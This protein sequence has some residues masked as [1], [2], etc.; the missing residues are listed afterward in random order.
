MQNTDA[1]RGGIFKVA[2][3]MITSSIIN[4]CSSFPC[5]APPVYIY[6]LTGSVDE[7]VEVATPED[8]ADIEVRSILAEVGIQ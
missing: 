8:I 5:L 3:R 1:L 4:G 2:G 6:L 7:A